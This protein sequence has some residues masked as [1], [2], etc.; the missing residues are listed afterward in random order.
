MPALLFLH[1]G[2]ARAL[3]LYLAAL[4]VWGLLAW[5]RGQGVSPNYRGALVIGWVTGL[6]QGA[7]GALLAL[8]TGGPREPLHLLYG[9]AIAVALPAGIVYAR[10]RS[11]ARQSLVLALVALF[12][13]GL[14]IRGITTS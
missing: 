2:F 5:R 13:A 12:T 14:A 8:S 11:P 10:D 3:V 7:L 6:F 1:A 9:V 4:G